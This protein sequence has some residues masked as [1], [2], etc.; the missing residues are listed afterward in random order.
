MSESRRFILSISV[1]R[2]GRVSAKFGAATTGDCACERRSV[3]QSR[4]TGCSRLGNGRGTGMNYDRRDAPN[5]LG[6]SVRD[7]LSP[8]QGRSASSASIVDFRPRH[9]MGRRRVRPLIGEQKSIAV[10]YQTISFD[11]SFLAAAQLRGR[12]HLIAGRQLDDPHG[13]KTGLSLRLPWATPVVSPHPSYVLC[14]PVRGA[15]QARDRA[16]AV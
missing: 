6:F 7:R 11:D 8:S 9:R 5:R 12:F 10:G 4:A 16:D 3:S 15:E 1:A 14:V 2:A 13:A